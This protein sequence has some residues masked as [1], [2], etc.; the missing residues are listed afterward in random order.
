MQAID[1]VKN[2]LND[3]LLFSRGLKVPFWLKR[4]F[5]Q[6]FG[7]KICLTVPIR[8][9]VIM[10]KCCKS[11]IGCE[12]CVNGWYSGSEALTKNC[13]CCR[14]EQ[15]Y[16]ETMLLRGLDEFLIEAKTMMLDSES[17]ENN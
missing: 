5:R 17:P 8:L 7:C 6:S 2:A 4:M 12:R 16:S 11:V 14:A 10:S 9:P 3:V 1:D 13:P 15:G